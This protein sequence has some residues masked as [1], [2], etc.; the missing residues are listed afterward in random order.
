MR[1]KLLILALTALA[2]ISKAASNTGNYHMTDSMWGW[3]WVGSF[4]MIALWLLV[5]LAIIY[6]VLKISEELKERGDE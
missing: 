3:H 6:L 1:E 5:I 2:L 4:F